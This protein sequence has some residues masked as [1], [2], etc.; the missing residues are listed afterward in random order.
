MTDILNGVQ[1]ILSRFQALLPRQFIRII[2]V[3]I[4]DDTF[5]LSGITPMLQ[6]IRS[7][8][9]DPADNTKCSLIFANQVSHIHEEKNHYANK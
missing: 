9:A 1:S 8:T 5:I 6:L 3:L 7:I 4:K 2:L